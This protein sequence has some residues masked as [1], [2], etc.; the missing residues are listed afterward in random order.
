LSSVDPLLLDIAGPIDPRSGW[1][2]P[3]LGAM[4]REARLDELTVRVVAPNP[5]RMALDGT[6][7]YLVG[8]A[9]EDEWA[10]VD[11]GP[12]DDT[13][14]ARVEAHLADAGAACRWILVTHH[15]VDH[16][17]AAASWAARLGATVAAASPEVAGPQGRLLAAGDNV[18]VAGTTV[19]VVATPGHCSDHLAFRLETGAV[20]VGDHILGR[21]TSVVTHP[22]GDLL[23]YLDSL[24]R[25]L[26]LGPDALFPGHGPEMVDDPAAVIEYYLAHRRFRERQII[27]LLSAHPHAVADLV[28]QIYRDVDP[29][30]WPYAEQ[31]TRAALQ[32]MV[33][34]GRVELSRDDIARLASEFPA[35]RLDLSS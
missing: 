28:A 30:L 5:S 11:P 1:D 16:A 19:R 4:P 32:M 14:L 10:I 6:N 33:T 20:L 13:H 18:R 35:D 22:E 17:E 31:S 21:G 2:V 27:A 29:N 34:Q 3:A 8:T 26:A 25:I 9:G 23:A 24:R 12:P 7:T 15:H